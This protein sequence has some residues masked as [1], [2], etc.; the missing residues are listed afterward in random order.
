MTTDGSC[1]GRWSVGAPTQRS[2]ELDRPDTQRYFE[3]PDDT[4]IVVAA[5]PSG[6]ER[7]P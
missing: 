4:A 1:T 6:G 7:Y 3:D 5:A 2:D